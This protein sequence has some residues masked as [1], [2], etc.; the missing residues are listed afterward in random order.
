[1]RAAL[2]TG[3]QGRLA[4]DRLGAVSNLPTLLR[5]VQFHEFLLDRLAARC[6]VGIVLRGLDDQ[7]FLHI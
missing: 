7:F 3:R 1:M 6:L 5:A 4:P 2:R